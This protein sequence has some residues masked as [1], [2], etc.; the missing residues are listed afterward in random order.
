MAEKQVTRRSFMGTAVAAGS[1]T[2]LGARGA[3]G[4]AGKTFKV[5]VV[6]CGGRGTGAAGNIIE[7]GKHAGVE[8]KVT[9]LADAFGDRLERANG[10]M[11]KRGTEVPKARCFIGY[12]AYKKV[13]DTDVDIVLMATPP[14]FRHV[15][16]E[17]AVKAGKHCFIEKPVA[18][19]GPGIRR[20]Y[21]A[22]EEATKK[23]LA[24]RAGTCLRH[25]ARYCNM[26]DQ[27][28]AG[29]IGKIVGGTIYY[30]T[31]ALW[32]KERQDDWS[33]ADYLARNW[34]SFVEMSG[35][36]IVEQHVH[37]ID[38]L[39][40]CVGAP[41]VAA[42]A[43]GG[44]HR[45]KTGNQYDCFGIDY[46][47]PDN[48]HV[49][50]I[51]RQISGCWSRGNGLVLQG[52]KGYATNSRGCY[53]RGEKKPVEKLSFDFKGGMYTQ[54]HITFLKSILDGKPI[55][56]AKDVTDGTLAAIIGRDAA[57][58]G[59]RI[60]FADYVTVNAKAP[61]GAK[62]LKPTPE[63]F[64]AGAVKVPAEVVPVPGKG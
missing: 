7:A 3:L 34:V 10:A 53:L 62:A 59:Q 51:S 54:E 43:V 16:F 32:R 18:V 17:A 38:M 5:G 42:V 31:G 6:G 12:D 1:L 40:W 21:A 45:R 30:C 52:E 48:V 27:I 39:N 55:N 29:T 49:M 15:H 4:Q 57:Y 9:A 13:M 41:P 36:H 37:T 2:L 26:H 25:D 44:R 58:T 22:G 61:L 46:E 47:Y 50:S 11:K 8:I 23:N 63:D 56:D 24:V 64:E 60:A 35:D 33:D 14:N 20:M 19:D 28:A